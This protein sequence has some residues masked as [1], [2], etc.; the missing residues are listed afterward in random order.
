MNFKKYAC[1]LL[2]VFSVLM[3]YAY[4][5]DKYHSQKSLILFVLSDNHITLERYSLDE[6]KESPLKLSNSIRKGHTLFDIDFSDSP[7]K[8]QTLFFNP[9]D[10]KYLTIL[11]QT[12]QGRD[13]Q[14]SWLPLVSRQLTEI[15]ANDGFEFDVT[16]NETSQGYIT[17]L[18]GRIS[19]GKRYSFRLLLDKPTQA[20]CGILI[21]DI[22]FN[23]DK[24]LFT[25]T[26]K[27]TD[28][29]AA[30]L[31]TYF[32][33]TATTRSLQKQ[34]GTIFNKTRAFFSH[35]AI[36]SINHG[37]SAVKKSGHLVAS[38][39]HKV[40]N[41]ITRRKTEKHAKACLQHNLDA[42]NEFDKML[43]DAMN[44]ELDF[45]PKEPHQ[46]SALVQWFEKAGTYLLMR[47][48]SLEQKIRN[49]WH[50]L[51]KTDKNNC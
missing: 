30:G 18:T 6:I 19:Q 28:L 21:S 7:Q 25:R 12:D 51:H 43:E 36:M 15:N 31:L 9:T 39:Y 35:Y 13:I 37:K 27:R 33:A 46:P 41:Y 38:I 47:Y 32:N 5:Y 11:S 2:F 29:N 16:N 49:N 34:I 48:I 50:K 20:A 8:P 40:K 3:Q 45:I 4:S 44:S 10:H 14:F 42:E 1:S 26:F 17:E 24:G 22:Y 23:Y